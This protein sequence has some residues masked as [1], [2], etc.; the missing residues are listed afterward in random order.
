MVSDYP[1]DYMH[2]VCLGVVKN[3]L[4]YWVRGVPHRSK[5]PGSP[6]TIFAL[7]HTSGHIKQPQ[8]P[9]V[10]PWMC[11]QSERQMGEE[12]GKKQSA[13]ACLLITAKPWMSIEE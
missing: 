12:V 13:L 6:E 2:L 3:L 11:K 10:F 5:V 9:S 1:L 8:G 7:T 4:H